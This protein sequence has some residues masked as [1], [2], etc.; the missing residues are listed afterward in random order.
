M[1][2]PRPP[3]IASGA[4]LAPWDA[5]IDAATQTG[6]IEEEHPAPGDA[7]RAYVR[8]FGDAGLLRHA[9]S[10]AP[11]SVLSICLV[12][13][14]LAFH[15]PLAELAFAMQGLG[16]TPLRFSSEDPAQHWRNNARNGTA[17]AAFALTEAQAG[18]DLSNI[19]T[20]AFKDGTQ[21]VLSG[22][23]RFISNAG[24]AD[25]YTVFAA[26]APKGERRRLT[27]FLVPS[28]LAGVST[29][30]QSVLGGHPI[31]TLTLDSVRVPE[32]FRIGEEGQ[33]LSIALHTLSRFR[34]S[35]GAAALG[36]A[37]RALS[38]SI[39]HVKTRRQFGAPLSEL[40]LVQGRL[41]DMACETDASRL[42]V[43]RAAQSI[44]ADAERSQ[45]T[46]ESSMAKLFATEAAQRVIDHAVQLL[47]GSGVLTDG[48]VAR[49]YQD[50]RALRIY[51]GTTDVH[52]TLIARS[53]L[54]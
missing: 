47:G 52:K 51:E 19:E 21:Y 4:S 42:L 1:N 44:D 7:L 5:A 16:A 13:Q 17:V 11:L 18:S 26:T 29:A 31:G 12:R 8:H 36:F 53:L 37:E 40:Q 48:V 25:F 39:A 22:E 3:V 15:S 54:Q 43:Y 46:Y 2:L 41:S 50:V 27:A 9:I 24:I 20:T 32:A 33:G 10:D 23:K 35:V 38:E 28:N 45:V 6:R 14:A 49:L 30:P 34:T